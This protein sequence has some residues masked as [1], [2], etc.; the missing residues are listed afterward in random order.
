MASMLEMRSLIVR[1][2]DRRSVLQKQLIGVCSA[3]VSF[4]RYV[5]S[6][7][8]FPFVSANKNELRP[9][10]STFLSVLSMIVGLRSV[11]IVPKSVW[12]NSLDR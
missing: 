6:P 2:A 12:I 4:D 8:C 5:P 11:E 3:L 10:S 9:L 1:G 7:R